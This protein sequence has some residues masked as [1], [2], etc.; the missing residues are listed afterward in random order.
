ML[1][2]PVLDGALLFAADL[3]RRLSLPLQLTWIGGQQLSRGVHDSTGQVELGLFRVDVQ[4]RRV[5]LL[6]DILDTGQTLATVKKLYVN[7]AR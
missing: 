7:G 3:I 2:V 5:L 6:D 4:G 1:F